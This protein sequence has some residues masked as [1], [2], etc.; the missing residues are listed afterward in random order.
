MKYVP[1]RPYQAS[2]T[3]GAP[4]RAPRPE[5][6][7]DLFVG[8]Y[9]TVFD[10]EM[11]KYVR[12]KRQQIS[13]TP[14]APD[15]MRRLGS[16]LRLGELSHINCPYPQAHPQGA[17]FRPP[18]YHESGRGRL[19]AGEERI[20]NRHLSTSDNGTLRSSP[21]PVWARDVRRPPC[22][23]CPRLHGIVNVKWGCAASYSDRKH[24]LCKQ[25]EART[26]SAML[27]VRNDRA[28]LE[29]GRR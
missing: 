12:L 25:H 10:P 1:L 15:Q 5:N 8:R 18:I 23:E 3:P 6:L 7:S 13:Q 24:M 11:M 22:M 16:L 21:G 27:S 29:D 4:D 9:Q 19:D 26:R 14:G 28:M 17:S 2:H 20:G